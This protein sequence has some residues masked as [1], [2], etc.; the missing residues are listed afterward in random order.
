M[1]L[2]TLDTSPSFSSLLL[3]EPLLK[4]INKMGFLYPTP[5]QQQA[6]P[7]ALEY[8]DLL[9]SAETGSGK[10]AAFLLPALRFTKWQTWMESLH[11]LRRLTNQKRHLC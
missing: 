11:L 5:V 3:A 4:A 6:I 1:Q 2:N 10:T 7:P 8:T 9:V